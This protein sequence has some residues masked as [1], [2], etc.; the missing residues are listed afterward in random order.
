MA[1]HRQKI[2]VEILQNTYQRNTAGRNKPAKPE[3]REAS[4]DHRGSM[5]TMGLHERLKVALC[6]ITCSYY[7]ISTDTTQAKFAI[8]ISGQGSLWSGL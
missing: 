5:T 1:G 6:C 3:A 4:V 8:L 2:P 7:L